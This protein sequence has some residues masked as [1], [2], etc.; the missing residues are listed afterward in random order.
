MFFRDRSFSR[1][2]IDRS[3]ASAPLKISSV[4]TTNNNCPIRIPVKLPRQDRTSYFPCS[5]RP[6]GSARGFRG[7]VLQFNVITNWIPMPVASL[8]PQTLWAKGSESRISRSQRSVWPVTRRWCKFYGDVTFL[9]WREAFLD[10]FFQ[11]AFFLDV[12]ILKRLGSLIR[13]IR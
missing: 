2:R 6:N 10:N 3:K 7:L 8:N 11:E 5:T 1:V 13:M 12:G 4:D 9:R